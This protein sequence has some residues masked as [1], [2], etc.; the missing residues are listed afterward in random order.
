MHNPFQSYQSDPT[1]IWGAL[2]GIGNPYSAM[3]THGPFQQL[4]SPNIASLYQNPY[5]MAGMQNPFLSLLLNPVLAQQ[6]ALQASQQQPYQMQNPFQQHNP[7]Q[8]GGI[9]SPF[10]QYGQFGSQLPPQTWI[11]QQG[12]GQQGIGQQGLGQQGFG[13]G[14]TGQGLGQIHPLLA[15]QL[16]SRIQGFGF[17]PWG[18]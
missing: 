5:G 8:Q 11:G 15:Q 4:G 9:G 1:Q 3:T 17:S 7:Y 14:L 2:A 16:A 18:F 12:L 13:Q 6:L 10:A